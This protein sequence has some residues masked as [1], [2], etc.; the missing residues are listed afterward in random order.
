MYRDVLIPL[1]TYLDAVDDASIDAAIDVAL[2]FGAAATG[3]VVEADLVLA[4]GVYADP[5]VYLPDLMVEAERQ[6]RNRGDA[7]TARF[8]ERA[9]AKRLEQDVQVIRG[10][11]GG[12]I[13]EVANRARFHD[14]TVFP[15]D[16]DNPI[17]RD[18]AEG[19]IFSSGRPVLLLPK[20]APAPSARRIVVAWDGSR[21]AARATADAMPLLQR[22]EQVTVVRVTDL[23]G[24]E[25]GDGAALRAHFV[26]HGL[27][28][29]YAET[30]AGGEGVAG[31]LR[32]FAGEAGADL[33]VMGGYGHSRMREFILGGLT[34]DLL[35][36]PFMPVL[37][38]H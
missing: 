24:P 28:V 21:N 7:L 19:V 22:A 35:H 11:S 32:R 8:R 6:G 29:R 38:A 13:D 27:D 34:R 18:C 9:Q 20:G 5:S 25:N 2:G 31:Q 1:L 14:V 12:V 30:A 37:M 10:L 15:L 26:R 3:L 33:L 17:A 36:A 23:K 4:A 16:P